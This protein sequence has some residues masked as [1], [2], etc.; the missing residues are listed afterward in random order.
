[1][2]TDPLVWVLTGGDDYALAATFPRDV[3][4]PPAW[5][6]IGVVTD[7]EGVFGSTAAAG[8]SAATNTSGDRRVCAST[9]CAYTDPVVA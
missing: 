9:A 5:T 4:L 8:R 2:N 7:G 3:Q 6:A 1:M